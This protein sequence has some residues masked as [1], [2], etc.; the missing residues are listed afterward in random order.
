[1]TTPSGRVRIRAFEWPDYDGVVRLW[2]DAGLTVGPSESREGIAL[3]LARD[4]GLFLVAE[5]DEQI[6]GAVLGA[7]DGRRGWVWHLAV[8]Q[9]RQ[10]QGIGR[11]LLAELEA[12][13][14]ARGCRK[15][16]LLVAPHNVGVVPFYESLGYRTGELV[17]ME[18]WLA[19]DAG[20]TQRVDVDLTALTERA[21]AGACFVCALVQRMPGSEHEVLFEDEDR[22]A[23]L[24]R[25]P[26]MRGYSIVAPRRHAE[27]LEL[28]LSKAEHLAL[29]ALVHDLAVALRR[30]LTVDRVY[31][32]SLGSNEGHAHV[33][34]HVAPLPPG[35][36]YERQQ[37]RALMA[38]YGVV[39]ERPE[40]RAPL[41]DR[42]R[43]TLRVE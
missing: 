34:W 11:A 4:P 5:I 21:R 42:I 31:V 43:G 29:Q 37:Y 24:S 12:R 23:F 28:D 38:E 19:D 27:R 18:K 30:A 41:A 1:M 7:F 8:D 40:E 13:L 14:A 15:V 3:R 22:I 35:V 16:N 17:F 10:R 20:Q 32:L 25:Y 39:D 2:A 33:H 6:V 36:P 9:D 26:T